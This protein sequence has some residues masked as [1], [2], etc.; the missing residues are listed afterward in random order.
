[1]IEDMYQNQIKQ[2]EL[3]LS[4]SDS[5]MYSTSI[6]LLIGALVVDSLFSDMS[7][8]INQALYEPTRIVLFSII[9]AVAVLPGGLAIVPTIKKVKS[10][11]NTKNKGLVLISTII[12]VIQYTIIGLLITIALQ[13]IFSM[14]YLTILLVASQAIS[15]LTGV[16]LMGI[17][18]FKFIQWYRAKRNLLV[19]LYLVSSLM[20]CGTL[21]ATII[22]QNSITMQ[23]S[24]F[25]VNSHS[26]EVKPFQANPERLSIMFAIISVANWIV[27]PLA[28][29]IW[30]AT[31][32]ML[33]HY[34]KI[35]GRVKYWILLSIPLLSLLAATISW[36]F[37]IPT[38]NLN[39]IFDQQVIFYTMLAFGGILTEGFLLSFAFMFISKSTQVN[40][41][42]KLKN[43]LLISA[44]GVA[45]LFTSFFANPSAGS[46]LPFGV[47]AT[48]FFG[49]GAYL[50]FAG[51]YSSA[52]SIA[53]DSSL[54]RTIRRSLLDQSK[55][56]DNIGLA[57]IN[58]ELEKHTDH[59]L[60]NHQE[61][62]KEA[63]IE[64][65]ISESDIENYVN[66]VMAEL[67][68]SKER[69]PYNE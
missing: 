2:R 46:Y 69:K 35:F 58:R 39:S 50:F 29:V 15:W 19:L 56:L 18:S 1:M 54:R 67:Q 60:K 65:S 66:E 28:Y 8:I 37:F 68:K 7:S 10:G 61:S 36:L 45:I 62:I 38:M 4:N 52:I 6:I 32:I 20:F 3:I 17:M 24:G 48:S 41:N 12:P 27:L 16:V 64:S 5:K 31:A 42:S 34:S 22:P 21:G 53:S 63:G 25:Y 49:F 33:N 43:Y 30:A 44:I 51:I 47:V 11:F 14:Q 55:L 9:L 13:I 57:D 40:T 26:T 59:V 23:S